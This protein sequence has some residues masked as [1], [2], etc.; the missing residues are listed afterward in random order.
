MS[1]GPTDFLNLLTS[2]VFKK[3]MLWHATSNSH[4][5]LQ[6]CSRIYFCPVRKNTRKEELIGLIK[7]LLGLKTTKEN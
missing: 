6:S 1:I 5:F 3:K 2:F 7:L 4:H